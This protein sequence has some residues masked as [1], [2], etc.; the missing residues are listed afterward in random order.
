VKERPIEYLSVP[1]VAAFVGITT[2]WMG[3]KMLFYPIDYRGIDARRW[4]NTPYG[5]FGW[6]GVVPCKTEIMAQR[7][8]NIVTTKLLSLEEGK[9]NGGVL[10][11]RVTGGVGNC[12]VV[13]VNVSRKL[14]IYNTSHQIQIH[15]YVHTYL[16][17]NIL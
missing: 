17:I 11:S 3:V 9:P 5:I 8:V 14:V 4:N 15:S 6:Q 1:C 13:T 7:L 12:R 2:N 10:E 16:Y